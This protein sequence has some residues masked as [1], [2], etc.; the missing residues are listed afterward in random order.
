[1]FWSQS[2]CFGA[3]EAR[4]LN[5]QLRLSSAL[6]ASIKEPK[7]NGWSMDRC[8]FQNMDPV[9]WVHGLQLGYRL[10]IQCVVECRINANDCG[11]LPLSGCMYL[12]CS[13]L[14]TILLTANCLPK[15]TR[16]AEFSSRKQR[17]ILHADTMVFL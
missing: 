14:S 4:N 1:M 17:D 5:G 13:Y 16:P 8:W 11:I 2:L 6:R 15:P 10:Y 7:G 3:E 9:Q 12:K